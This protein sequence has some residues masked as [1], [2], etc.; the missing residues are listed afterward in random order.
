MIYFRF[1]PKC[2]GRLNLKRVE[3]F[4]R[5][6]CAKCSFVFYEN[7]RPTASAI[8]FKDDKVL[9]VKRAIEPRRGFWDLPGGFLEKDEHPEE[10]LR[11]E[12]KEELCVEIEVLELL[13]IYMDQYGYDEAGSHTLNIYYLVKIVSGEPKPASD[14]Q[15]LEWFDKTNL[16]QKIAFE[17]NKEALQAWRN[18]TDA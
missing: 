3:E 16:P 4:E 17:N 15:G 12:L 7:P 1:C 8:I 5:L 6:V 11:R 14:I 18:R 2:G 13:G 9:L 10:A